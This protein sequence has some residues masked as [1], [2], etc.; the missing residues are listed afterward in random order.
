MSVVDFDLLDSDH[1]PTE[2]WLE[3][4]R[5][6]TPQAEDA[7]PLEEFITLLEEGWYY[8]D[9]GY[10]RFKGDRLELHTAGWSGNEELLSVLLDNASLMEVLELVQE[11]E[12][13]HY[14]FDIISEE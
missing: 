13:G 12:G 9:C 8:S 3:F 1:Y 7:L 10:F 11:R 4:V 14:Y 5:D 6:Y 2:K